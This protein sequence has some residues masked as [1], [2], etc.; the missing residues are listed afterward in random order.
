[1]SLPTAFVS[2]IVPLSPTTVDRWRRCRRE[3]LL[4]NVLPVPRSAAG[5]RTND[6][7]NEGLKAHALLRQL[8]TDGA[9]TCRDAA[10]R[11]DLVATYDTGDGDRLRGFLERHVDKCPRGSESLGHERGLARLHREP[12]PMFMAY[13][14]IDAVWKHDGLLDARD[15]K[16]GRPSIER[17]EDDP[18]AQVQAF[19]LAP[20][21]R[22]EGL[23]LRIG[24]ELLAPEADD[25]PQPFEPDP[26]QLDHIEEALRRTADEIR[27]ERDFAGV[28]DPLRCDW[29][30]YNR[31]CTHAA[32]SSETVT[33]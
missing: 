7:A 26:E 33:R 19:L 22:H 24:Y 28:S 20:L 25:D 32:L 12:Q 15:Y 6:Q 1:M 13:G 18:A 10:W 8:H 23:R 16:T 3:Y 30:S 17:V 31:I 27:A 2:A 5:S 9:Q 14:K 4:A 21:A 29:C 11:H